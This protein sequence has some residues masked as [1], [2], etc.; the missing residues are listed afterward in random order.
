MLSPV[1]A[2]IFLGQSL[3]PLIFQIRPLKLI[4]LLIFPKRHAEKILYLQPLEEFLK[5]FAY[6]V[7]SAMELEDREKKS[8]F[9]TKSAVPWPRRS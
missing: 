5:T 1:K 9:E 7:S 8:H 2:L 6:Y 3:T 4:V